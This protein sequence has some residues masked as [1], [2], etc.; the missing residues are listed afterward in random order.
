MTQLLWIVDTQNDFFDSPYE[1][2]GKGNP[3]PQH[4]RL[5]SPGLA[6][7]DSF[8]IRE[9]LRELV[10]YAK[11]QKTWKL[12]GSLDSHTH[13]DV[14]HFSQWPIHCLKG[15][16]GYFPIP[17]V[18]DRLWY[19]E[20]IPTVGMQAYTQQELERLIPPL[21]REI[22]FFEKGE[23]PDDTDPNAC[24]SC[25]VNPNVEPALRL[26]HPDLI[27]IC[28]LALGYCVKEARNYFKEL[29]YPVAL[30]TDAIKEFSAEEL[31]LYGSWHAE[32]DKLVH[33]ADV[34]AGKL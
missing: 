28:G 26:M 30:V 10:E 34:L 33:T 4:L 11:V 19:E 12:A 25:R 9:N 17:E 29:G 32:G 22:V 13:L 2:W 24:N 27:V 18:D 3:R 16:P 1:V 20:S 31:T 21:H 15:Q 7:P 5:Q 6:V 23:R 14:K 8:T